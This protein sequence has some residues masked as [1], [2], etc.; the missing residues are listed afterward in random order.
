MKEQLEM[1]NSVTINFGTG[2]MTI[3]NIILAFVM[4][5]VALGL[6]PKMLKEIINKP[7]SILVGVLL[8]WVALPAVTF[9]IAFILNPFIT[10][11]IALG[12]LLV[13]SCPGGNMSNFLSSLSN[14]NTALSISL[15]A[16]TTSLA[17]IVTP[18]NFFFWGSLY[19]HLI[20]IKNDIPQLMIRFLPMLEQIFLLLGLPIV[21]GLLFAH[22]FPKATKI[23][24]KPLQVLS[25]LL[26]VGMVV[27]SLA[28]NFQIFIDNIFY[29]FFI[30]MVHNAA[31]LATGYY[32]GQLFGLSEYNKRTLTIET[33]IQN[34]GLGLILLFNPV[35]F[36]PETWHGQYRGMLFLTAWWGIWHIIS[37]LCV[38][39]HFR[40]KD[41]RL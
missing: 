41:K 11:M 31:A 35:I 23:I 19:S 1:L 39:Y 37:G 36:P 15:T 27:V 28:Q 6:K 22:F 2:G 17:P 7:K 32:G 12:M 25:V 10:P 26:F 20:S 33:G 16:I 9:T 18:F 14:G 3:V 8:Q 4:F 24:S 13:A 30:V 40:S 34:S 21:L 5:G 29:V 38:A